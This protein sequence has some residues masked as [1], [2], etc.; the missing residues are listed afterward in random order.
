MILMAI[1]HV[2]LYGGIPA[3]GESASLFFTRW[4]THFSAPG[5]AFFAGTSIFLMSRK[6]ND[7]ASLSKFLLKRG[8]L[9]VLLEITFIRLLWAF[10][11]DYSQFFLAG[12]IW[13]LGWCMVI[14]AFFVRFN[15]ATLGILGLCIMAGQ[16]LFHYVPNVLPAHLGDSFSLFWNFIYPTDAQSPDN[17]A[18]LYVIVPWIGVMAAGYGFGLVIEMEENRRRNFK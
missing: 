18:I 17:I 4:I 6:M 2:R 1:D 12:V 3:G 10:K 9:L 13:M 16:S 5:F 15:A 11:I 14:M 7:F 8:L